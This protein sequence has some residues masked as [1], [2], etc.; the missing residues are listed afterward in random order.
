MSWQPL[1]NMRSCSRVRFQWHSHQF[2]QRVNETFECVEGE[3]KEPLEHQSR[4]DGMKPSTSAPMMG[5]AMP[6]L[7]S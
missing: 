2:E 1:Q 5:M 3:I 6:L 7:D 4:F